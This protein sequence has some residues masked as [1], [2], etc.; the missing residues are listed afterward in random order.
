MKL[1]KLIILTLYSTGFF[2]F[3]INTMNEETVISKA[4]LILLE[5]IIKCIYFKILKRLSDQLM[6]QG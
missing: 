3:I 6:T 4:S 2:F 5:L 1:K